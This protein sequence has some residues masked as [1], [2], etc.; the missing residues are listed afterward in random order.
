MRS[1]RVLEQN[2]GI[3]PPSLDLAAARADLEAHDRLR[4]LRQ[5]PPQG[6]RPGV[7]E[8]GCEAID[9]AREGGVGVCGASKRV[10]EGRG[11]QALSGSGSWLPIEFALPL[12]VHASVVVDFY[13]PSARDRP[14]V[15]LGEAPRPRP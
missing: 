2:P 3:M 14:R 6:S 1:L 7:I 5:D 4:P 10:G 9:A 15:P 8:R 11:G 12:R 13:Q